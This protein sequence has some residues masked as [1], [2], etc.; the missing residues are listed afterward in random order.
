MTRVPAVSPIT[1]L[2]ALAGC[3]SAARGPNAELHVRNNHELPYAGA[4][5][6]RTGLPDGTY[7]GR[8]GVGEVRSGLARVVASLPPRGEVALTRSGGLRSDPFRAGP[9]SVAPGGSALELR[10]ATR[11]LGSL[12]LGLVMVPGRAATVDDVAAHF[13]PLALAWREQAGGVWAAEA[14]QQGFRLQFTLRRYGGGWA[15]VHARLIRLD[16][17][18]GPAYAA[19]VRRVTTP[20]LGGVKL[21]FNGRVLDAEDSPDHWERD[22]WYT[23]GVDWTRWQAGGLALLSIGGFTPAPALLRDGIWKEGS[24]F[25]V[26]ELTRRRA[27]S[28]YLVSEVSGPN[29]HQRNLLPYAPLTQGDVVDLKW[30]LAVSDA[31]PQGWEESQLRVF[32]GTRLST[33]SAPSAAAARVDLGVPAVQF[34]T[35]YFPYST[36]AENF[37]FYRTPALDRE[38]WW[39]FSPALWTQW[40]AFVPQ[41]QTDLHII[42]A[43]GFEWVRPHHLELLQQMERAE[44]LAFLD[45]YVGTVRALGMKVLV[46]TEGPAEW[47]RLIAG[48]YPDV[49]TRIEIENE[50]LIPGIGPGDAERWTELYRTVKEVAPQT[51]AFLTSAGNHGIFERL[52]ALGVPFDRVGLH[53][54]KHGP[55]WQEAFRTHALGTGGY[56]SDLG[57]PATLGEFNWKE[58]TRFSPEKRRALFDT[59]YRMMLEPR[60]IPKFI[61]FHFQETLCVNPS[62][63]R[64]GIRHYETI[65]LDRRPKPEALALMRLIRE[66]TRADAPVRELPIE[67]PEVRFTGGRATAAFTLSNRSGRPLSVRLRPVAFGGV[68]SRLTSAQ[69]VTLQPGE[70]ARGELEVQLSA[71]APVGTYHHFLVAEYDDQTAYGWGVAANPGRPTFSATP[72]LG[73]RVDYPQ[74]ADMVERIDW[75]RP[76]AVVFGARAPVLELEMAYLLAN[77]LQ[78][79]TGRPVWLSS[80]ED[81][82]DSLRAGTLF[83]VG[84]R[85]GNPW[86]A[87]L[88]PAFST[89]RPSVWLQPQPNGAQWVVVSG[90]DRK[91]VQAAATDLV[92]RYWPQAKDAAAR[93]GRLQ[94]GAALGNRAGVTDPDPP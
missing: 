45:F 39:P 68:R 67:L 69:R 17:T 12:E 75:E 70:M 89:A 36:F 63:S 13:R 31:P 77:T 35:S 92:L 86:V 76:L 22:F 94:E 11:P 93:V 65:A 10:W 50:V 28:L 5:E 18:G 55:E 85:A 15:D 20:G 62:L 48:R 79:A 37:D 44:A 53:A 43:M 38:T 24:R 64:Q 72:A 40:R 87:A 49:I 57:K 51:E 16:P 46:D 54:Y 83:V 84:S 9:L 8:N 1:L 71:T 25:Y 3:A 61:Q 78:S 73:E 80:A 47:V 32:A 82:P 42:R 21:R 90:P 88:P 52:R 91:G 60:A 58:Y 41:M 30:R 27:D 81:L 66:H 4:V 19:L 26:W 14:E 33:P 2:L 56:A 29:P 23:H 59:T 7:A 6:V 74:G 34:G